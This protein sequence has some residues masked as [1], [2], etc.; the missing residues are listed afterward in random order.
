MAMAMKKQHRSKLQLNV[1]T[2]RALTDVKLEQLEQVHGGGFKTTLM[3]VSGCLCTT[4]NA[5][6]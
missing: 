6:C 5:Q 2:L 4:S 1:E 3:A